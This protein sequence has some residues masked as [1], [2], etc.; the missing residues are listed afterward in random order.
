[1][2]NKITNQGLAR[3]RAKYP[4][5][6]AFSA[7]LGVPYQVVQQWVKNGVPAEYCPRIEE[8]TGV[9]SEDM[10]DKVNWEFIR[11]TGEKR[12]RI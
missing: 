1:M 6:R 12:A 10:N 7:A 3:A 5:L 8:L 9:Q 2:E 4:T 11:S